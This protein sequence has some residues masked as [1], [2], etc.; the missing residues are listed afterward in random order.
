[1]IDL[2]RESLLTAWVALRSQKLRSLLVIMSVAIGAGAITLMVSLSKS[3]IGTIT[4]GLEEAGGVHLIFISNR[5]PSDFKPYYWD[6]GL[7][8]ADA[9]ALRPALAGA[10]EVQF[11]LPGPRH[12]PIT[13]GEKRGFVDMAVGESYRHYLNQEIAFGHDLPSDA[14]GDRSR[15]TLICAPLA[16]EL[17]GS[18]EDAIGKSI[19]AF[20]HRFTIVGV[21]KVTNNSGM[22]FNDLD[23][24][25]VAFFSWATMVL[26]EGFT[27]DGFIV[28]HDLAS[29]S[30]PAKMSHE[31]IIRIA[32]AILQ[33]RHHFADDVEF[34][35]LE[36]VIARFEKIFAALRLLTGLVAAVS[37]IIAGAGI[38]NVL[39]ASLRERT[40]EIGI[41]RSIGA[42]QGDLRRQL[43]LE[44]TLL[45]GTGG[46]IGAIIGALMAWSTDAFGADLVP[47]WHAMISVPAALSAVLASLIA[48]I[49]FGMAPAQRA[50]ALVVT[51][52]LRG[53]G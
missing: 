1:M 12:V 51:E 44:S 31:Q 18:E 35:D 10:A 8:S 30:E 26:E 46:V 16:R 39:L 7:P 9:V 52:C 11:I 41:R 3:A 43:L 42:S 53:E 32:N 4:Q 45:A 2:W 17:F 37:L 47:N 33:Q 15:V 14:S 27:D 28:I 20:E 49:V 21:T 24:T 5:P 36:A 48:G 23:K 22:N 38:M 6:K 25:H 13:A 19:V 29:P 50:A 34:V 40:S